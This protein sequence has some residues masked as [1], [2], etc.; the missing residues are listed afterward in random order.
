MFHLN[1]AKDKFESTMIVDKKFTDFISVYNGELKVNIQAGTIPENG[2]NGIQ[3][4]DLLSFVNE[5][6]KSLDNSFPCIENK[7]TILKLEEALLWQE[8]RTKDKERRKVEGK[9]LK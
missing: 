2:V 3:I 9:D 6:Y 8:M 5:V 1:V 7:Q 4:T